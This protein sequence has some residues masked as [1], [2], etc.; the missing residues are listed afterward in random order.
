MDKTIKDSVQILVDD[1]VAKR[2][3]LGVGIPCFGTIML[4]Q[5]AI[6]KDV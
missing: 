6:Y 5:D 3:I 4:F 2:D 1:R